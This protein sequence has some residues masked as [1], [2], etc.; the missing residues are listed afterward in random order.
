MELAQ[1]GRL[2]RNENQTRGVAIESVH[3]F[4]ITLL[5]VELAQALYQT[6]VDATATV[7][8][9]PGRLVNSH[10]T[11]LVEYDSV[12]NTSRPL[13][14]NAGG[15]LAIGHHQGGHTH[16]IAGYQAVFDLG[17]GLIH[18]HLSLSDRPIHPSLGHTRKVA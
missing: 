5:G 9:E 13:A 14:G 3:Q 18:P 16:H 15:R 17:A 12:A 10:Q 7:D 11:V 8:C 2:L 4:Q 6:D 1:G